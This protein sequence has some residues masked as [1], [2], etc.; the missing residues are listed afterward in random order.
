MGFIEGD[1]EDSD[2]IKEAIGKDELIIVTANQELKNKRFS[3]ADIASYRWVLREKGSGTRETFLN[4]IK[5]KDI[6]LNIFLELGH[7]ESI[8]SLL[9][10]QKPITCI[11]K[12]AVAKEIEDGTLFEVKVK[13]FKCTRDFYAIYHKD[14]YKSELFNKLYDFSKT[15]IQNGMQN[16]GCKVC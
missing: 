8:K 13:G 3:L 10:S 14:K 4:Y 15:T 7:T 6:E 11:S 5:D 2:I 9:L 1:V 12:L 16:R